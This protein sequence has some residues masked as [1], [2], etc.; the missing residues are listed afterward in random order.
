MFSQASYTGFID[1][2]PIELVTDIYSDGDARAIYAYSKFDEPIVTEGR[3]QKNKLTLYEKD[4]P[5]K[6]KQY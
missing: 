6:T 5:A 3:L 1:K 2:Y 4:K